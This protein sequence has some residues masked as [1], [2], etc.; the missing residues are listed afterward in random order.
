MR[1]PLRT[2]SEVASVHL[3]EREQAFLKDV[4]DGGEEEGQG[5]KDEQLVRQ[6]SPVVLEDK[7]P[8]E[9]DGS[10]HVFKLL[11]GFLHRPG[12]GGWDG[13]EEAEH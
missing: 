1:S 11:V 10:G 12:R 2:N 3:N 7:F 8:A 6:L 4:Q 9:V 13:K 5:Q